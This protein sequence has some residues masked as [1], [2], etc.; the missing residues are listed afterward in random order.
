MSFKCYNSKCSV[1]GGLKMTIYAN[2]GK[3]TR[4]TCSCMN[5]KAKAFHLYFSVIRDII[6]DEQK[7]KLITTKIIDEIIQSHL[8]HEYPDD[9]YKNL[10]YWN[11]VKQQTEKL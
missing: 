7:A 5:T 11:E 3:L 8:Y 2:G 10:K 6:A 1:C 4:N 9:I